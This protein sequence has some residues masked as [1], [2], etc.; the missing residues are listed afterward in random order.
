MEKDSS[1][2]H[3]RVDDILK[4]DYLK[5]SSEEYA[6]C[7]KK[8]AV[9]FKNTF[10]EPI[11]VPEIEGGTASVDLEHLYN[12]IY[13]ANMKI[14]HILDILEAK[15]TERN[16]FSASECVNISGSG[17]RF[18]ANR[19]FSIDDIIALRVFLPLS[20]SSRSWI[21]ILG[22]VKSVSASDSENR[23]NTAIKFID[24]ADDDREIIIRYVFTRQRELLRHVSDLK[25][26]D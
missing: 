1:R 23:Y 7:K 15:N 14:D 5:V 13:Q 21:N 10:G 6:R 11:K 26:S 3:V 24:L 17:M 12:L 19:C 25:T 2:G 16:I 20:L 9:I 18:I 4:V 8:P 22:K